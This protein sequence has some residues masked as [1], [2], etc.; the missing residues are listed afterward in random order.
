MNII[1]RQLPVTLAGVGGVFVATGG[2]W[3]G[4]LL[5][6]MAVTIVEFGAANENRS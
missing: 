4:V 6:F 3:E 2:L 1:L 5:F